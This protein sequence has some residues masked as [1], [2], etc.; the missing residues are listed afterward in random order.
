MLRPSGTP[1]ESLQEDPDRGEDVLAG[2]TII[3][4]YKLSHEPCART[5]KSSQL[6]ASG[7]A[8]HSPFVTKALAL[9]NSTKEQAY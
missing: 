4:V 8:Q 9:Q 7:G 6:L 5:E 1:Q 3:L 2:G